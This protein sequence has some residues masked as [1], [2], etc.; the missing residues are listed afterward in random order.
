MVQG[1]PP[2]SPAR[3][4]SFEMLYVQ[5]GGVI[6][7][8]PIALAHPPPWEPASPRVLPHPRPMGGGALRGMQYP[9]RCLMLSLL[10]T[11]GN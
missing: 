9:L 2:D 4:C 5:G 8:K 7:G 1:D 10:E 11:R 3:E 6:R